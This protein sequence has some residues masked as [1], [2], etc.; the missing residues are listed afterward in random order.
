MVGP[1]L[2]ICD[3]R[4]VFNLI[5]DIDNDTFFC[6]TF[7]TCNF[8]FEENHEKLLERFRHISLIYIFLHVEDLVNRS[9]DVHLTSFP[10]HLDILSTDRDGFLCKRSSDCC[11]L[12]HPNLSD[13]K[14]A[15]FE[16]FNYARELIT[17][18]LWCFSVNVFE[19]HNELFLRIY[20]TH[21]FVR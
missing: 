6:E 10:S 13:K 11:S 7:Y 15:N 2:G 16:V 21:K 17:A 1:K 5:Q 8:N 4:N 18:L 14:C 9:S 12:C 19:L 20:I 3:S